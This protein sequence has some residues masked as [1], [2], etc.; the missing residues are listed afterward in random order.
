M[1]LFILQGEEQSFDEMTLFLFVG[2]MIV[3]FFFN[4][5]KSRYSKKILWIISSCIIVIGIFLSIYAF[6]NDSVL[7]GV[8]V[9]FFG[10][11]VMPL[12]DV[13]IK[14]KSKII[15]PSS[16]PS[17]EGSNVSDSNHTQTLSDEYIL[18]GKSFKDKQKYKKAIDLFVKA[19]SVNPESAISWYELGEINLIRNRIP[20]SLTCYERAVDIKPNYPEAIEKIEEVKQKLNDSENE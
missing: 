4:K 16:K 2:L 8:V 15:K 12:K 11:T 10:I 13:L 14:I 5:I 3:W 17:K 7:F 9:I 1:F 20:E 19:L 6:P 18:K